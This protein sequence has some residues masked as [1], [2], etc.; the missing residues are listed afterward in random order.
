ME[1]MK[2]FF[3][4]FWNDEEGLQTLEIMLIIAVIVVI[5]LL[6]RT[7]IMEWIDGLLE[8]GDDTIDN[9]VD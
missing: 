4:N 3:T 9:F 6:F 1:T 7:Q 8:F 2:T 5:A